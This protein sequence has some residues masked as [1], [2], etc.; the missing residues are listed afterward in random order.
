M[1]PENNPAIQLV[2]GV[3][4]PAHELHLTEWMGKRKLTNPDEFVGGRMNYQMHKQREAMKWVRDYSLAVDVGGHCGLWSMNLACAFTKVVA[5]EPVPLH[6]EC[7]QLN[8]G[9]AMDKVDLIAACAG[10]KPGRANMHTTK[11]SSGDSWIE[12]LQAAE[13]G[14]DVSYIAADGVARPVGVPVITIDSLNLPSLGFIKL[15]T[16]G[17]EYPALLGAEATLKKYRPAVCVEQKPGKGKT[18]GYAET[19]AVEYLKSLGAVLRK[20]MSGDFIMSWD[21]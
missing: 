7:F 17:F 19:E 16:E 6:R 5:F 12:D 20:E 8:V 11:G 18:F 4:L 14:S 2:M 15:D 1:S 9:S 10:E 21:A 3:Y 13:G